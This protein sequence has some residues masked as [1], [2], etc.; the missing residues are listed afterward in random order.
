M[1]LPTLTRRNSIG[2]ATAPCASAVADSCSSHESV[3]GP[4]AS[5]GVLTQRLAATRLPGVKPCPR[6]RVLTTA[7]SGAGASIVAVRDAESVRA[8]RPIV[9]ATTW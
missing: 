2:T 7:G 4:G 8:N 9:S 3:A 5:A 1:P 6:T